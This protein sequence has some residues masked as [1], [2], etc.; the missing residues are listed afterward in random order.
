LWHA[1]TN[2]LRE[3]TATRLLKQVRKKQK[4]TPKDGFDA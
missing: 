1:S 2:M 3:L 4:A